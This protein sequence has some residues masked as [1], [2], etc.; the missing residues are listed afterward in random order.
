MR[1]SRAIQLLTLLNNYL[2][3]SEPKQQGDALMLPVQKVNIHVHALFSS[4]LVLI[5][6]NNGVRSFRA[7]ERLT[8]DSPIL[9]FGLLYFSI[10]RNGIDCAD[11]Q[12]KNQYPVDDGVLPAFCE[13]AN[14]PNCFVKS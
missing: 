8:F 6:S 10:N 1:R 3:V 11:L 5:A 4:L 9:F 12:P 2:C 7:H 14:V 13:L